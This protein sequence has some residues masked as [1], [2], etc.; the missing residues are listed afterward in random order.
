MCDWTPV[1]NWLIAALVTMALAVASVFVALNLSSVPQSIA[2]LVAAA[3]T[4]LAIGLISLALGALTAFCACAGPP[5][6]GPCA[7]LRAVLLAINVVLG[8]QVAACLATAAV[9]LI[10]ILGTWLGGRQIYVIY[11]ALVLQVAL[12]VSAFAF[13]AQLS[14]CQPGRPPVMPPPTTPPV[15]TG[16][17][18]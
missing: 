11:G 6:A 15:G 8:I 14:S 13:L 7:N 1:R 5:C 2:M 10:P 18:G 12:L 16:P 4:G 3:M 17:V 9:V